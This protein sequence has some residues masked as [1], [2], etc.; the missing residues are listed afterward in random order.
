MQALRRIAQ[1][2]LS[3][4]VGLPGLTVHAS[5]SDVLPQ[6][7]VTQ[8]TQ[9]T[10]AGSTVAGSVSATAPT[11]G[12]PSVSATSP[13]RSDSFGVAMSAE[14][15]DGHRGG[16]ALISNNVLNGAVS[17][18]SARHVVTGDNSITAGSFANAS[19][20]PTV[21]QNSGANVLIQNATILNVRFGN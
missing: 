7:A 13:A 2:V 5:A 11:D 18:N 21:I 8:S 4:A 3:V 6:P 15:L 20:L 19:G 14:Q 9:T 10:Q 16:D 1:L 17:D 12:Q